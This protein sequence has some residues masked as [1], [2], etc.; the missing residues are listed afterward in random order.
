MTVRASPSPA[1]DA[2]PVRAYALDSGP[3]LLLPLLALYALVAAVGQPGSRP[4]GDEAPLLRLSD[5][6]LHGH[7][8]VPG[9]MDSISYLWHGPGTPLLLTPLVALDLPLVAVRFVGPVLLF[10]AVLLFYRL[11]RLRLAPRAALMG[12]CAFG[13]YVPFYEGLPSLHKEP[14]AV[15]LVTAAL[16]WTSRLLAGG[17]RRHLVL[18]GL[19]LGGLAMVRLEY[20]WLALALLAVSAAWWLLG[21]DRAA[22]RRIVGVCL[23]ALATCVP[24][25]IYTYEL[26]GHALYWGN[27]GGSSLYWMSPT[28]DLRET[29]QWHAVHTVFQDPSLSGY[30]PL[31]TGLS[32]LT[33]VERDETLSHT[34]LANMRARPAL[35]VRNL[36]ANVIRLWFLQPFR[37][38]PPTGLVFVY[39]VVNSLL[40]GAVAWAAVMLVR[41]RARL[42]REAL[43]F[44]AFASGA[45][46]VHVVASAEPRMALPAVPALLWLVAHGVRRRPSPALAAAGQA[47]E[48][49]G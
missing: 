20:G 19:A 22:A 47:G 43:P 6:I 3:L 49:S 32:R 35:Y 39:A 13:L 18:A 5:R 36:A 16:L 48:S 17:R 4:V 8:A 14:L 21:A 11:L 42:P 41:Q 38:R 24:W 2:Q 1:G 40:L 34:A 7:Y 25:L 28:G 10:A 15:L 26:T 46:L 31:F 23:V 12:T 44:A 37:P 9:T 27:S 30:R 45:L 29:G 33:P